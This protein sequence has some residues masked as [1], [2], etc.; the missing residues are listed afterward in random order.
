MWPAWSPPGGWGA[1]ALT[2]SCARVLL[3]SRWRGSR[4]DRSVQVALRFA[5]RSASISSRRCPISFSSDSA[6][7][8]PPAFV[9]SLRLSWTSA[10]VSPLVD[11]RLLMMIGWSLCLA[12]GWALWDRDEGRRARGVSRLRSRSVSL[13]PGA[14]TRFGVV[15]GWWTALALPG[16]PGAALR[17]RCGVASVLLSE[18]CS[19]RGTASRSASRFGLCQR[20][21]GYFGVLQKR[22]FANKTGVFLGFQGRPDRLGKLTLYH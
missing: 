2:T 14:S 21:W 7:S 6:A 18:G 10:T 17:G 19:R 13:S 15:S 8:Q 4:R 22:G 5:D 11:G 12:H 3:R 9:P 1:S 20:K 16:S